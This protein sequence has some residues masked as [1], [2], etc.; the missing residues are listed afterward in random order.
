MSRFVLTIDLEK[1]A[2]KDDAGDIAEILDLTA[3]I[4][5]DNGFCE[6]TQIMVEGKVVGQWDLQ[7][8]PRVP[9]DVFEF[10]KRT[11][12]GGTDVKHAMKTQDAAMELFL[13]YAG[14]ETV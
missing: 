2:P 7:G 3:G 12:L 10:I 1:M 14:C 11:S 5:R 4:L 13:K 8:L 6:P 9:A